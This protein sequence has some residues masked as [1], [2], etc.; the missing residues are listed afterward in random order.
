MT[1]M[2]TDC[3]I[4]IVEDE[5]AH[6]DL[7][8]RNLRRAGLENEI[9]AF[10]DGEEALVFLLRNAEGINRE[11]GSSYQMLLDIGLPGMSDIETLKEIKNKEELKKLP[12]TM[13]T[14]TDDPKEINLYYK[15]GCSNYLVKPVEYGRLV[16]MVQTLARFFSLV[17]SPQLNGEA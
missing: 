1:Q 9:Q 7:I 5:P 16:E 11:P 17:E 4:L 6:R 2:K 8:E 12:V 3:V 14:T 15:L 13:L 10:G